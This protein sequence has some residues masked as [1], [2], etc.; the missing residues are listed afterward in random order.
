VKVTYRQAS[1]DDVTRQLRYY[2]VKLNR[3]DVAF[4][5][6]DA[7]KKTAKSI[8]MRPLIAAPYP[9]RNPYLQNLRSLPVAGF[10]MIRFYFLLENDVVR[11][12]RILHGKWDIST[13][14]ERERPAEN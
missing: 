11:V 7:I 14:L 12:I 4:R 6:R 2:L 1:R 9:L 10:E 3:P 8:G 13:I 5:F